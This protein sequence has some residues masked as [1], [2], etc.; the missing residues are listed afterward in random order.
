[1]KEPRPDELTMATHEIRYT[2]RLLPGLEI[3]LAEVGNP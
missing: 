2:S 1:M 3:L